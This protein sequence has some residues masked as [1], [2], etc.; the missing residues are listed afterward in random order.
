MAFLRFGGQLTT[1]VAAIM[2]LMA[3]FGGEARAQEL[4]RAPQVTFG[5]P[6]RIDG[7]AIFARILTGGMAQDGRF[8]IGDDMETRISCFSPE[9][10]LLWAKGSAGE[11][12]GEFRMLYRVAVTPTGGV[13]AFDAAKASVTRYD[14]LGNMREQLHLPM[15]FS[16][17]SSLVAIDDS[18]FAVA[19][20]PSS[21]GMASDSAIHMF[22]IRD[23]ILHRRSF[24]GLPVSNDQVKRSMFG[25]GLL[26]SDGR[27]LY[28]SRRVPY[29][30]TAYS[31]D[32]VAEQSAMFSTPA[33]TPVEE[34]FVVQRSETRTSFGFAPPQPNWNRV[35]TLRVLSSKAAFVGRMEGAGRLRLDILSLPSL[36]LVSTI[37]APALQGGM[38]VLGVDRV[39]GRLVVG[40][41]CDDEPCVMAVPFKVF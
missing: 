5:I 39:R 36:R 10:E 17:V 16:Q 6:V 40:T 15:W 19:G 29:E 24:G 13:L 20:A 37:D 26:T 18:T 4:A 3:G 38:N 1:P 25:A 21:A 12:P 14:D 35:S 32:G 9:G 2:F 31:L 22:V 30:V 28:Y 8:C 41:T 7:G 23:S 11:G 34:L 33:V 27:H